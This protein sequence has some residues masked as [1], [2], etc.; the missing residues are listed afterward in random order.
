M[1][2]PLCVPL[3][4]N[5]PTQHMGVARVECRSGCSC[6]KTRLDGT[7]ATPVSLQQIHTFRVT[8]HEACVIR[9]TVLDE[10]GEQPSEGHKARGGGAACSGLG[11]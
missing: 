1:A 11:A 8:Q 6:D 2:L 9:V 4:S 10:D 3:P 5:N 7:W